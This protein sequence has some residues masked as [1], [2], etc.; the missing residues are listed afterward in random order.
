M[1]YRIYRTSDREGKFPP[2]INAYKGIQCDCFGQAWYI[3]INTL[4]ELHSLQERVRTPL[5]ITADTI[6]IYDTFRE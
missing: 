4:E 5:I 2:C 6:E 1:K 3:N